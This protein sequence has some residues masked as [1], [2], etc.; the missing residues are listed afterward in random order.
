M[1]FPED[2][3]LGLDGVKQSHFNLV[4]GSS[5]EVDID[6]KETR[7]SCFL[8]FFPIGADDEEIDTWCE[9]GP[10]R[11]FFQQVSPGIHFQYQPL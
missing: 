10:N 6:F 7:D 3:D 2:T 5:V 4:Y 1:F 11:F 9:E 8:K